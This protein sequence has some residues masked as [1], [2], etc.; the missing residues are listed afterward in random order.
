MILFY[1]ALLAITT[2]ALIFGA[3]DASV[4]E[5]GI[6]A[7]VAEEGNPLIT[8]WAGV[9]PKP[10]QITLYNLVS[11]SVPLFVGLFFGH[12][13]AIGGLMLGWQCANFVDHIKG[14]KEWNW[15]F[16]HP[17][18]KLPDD[19]IWQKFGLWILFQ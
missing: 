4:T 17:G 5:K 9:T 1:I 12:E 3:L 10:W 15:L 6:S 11:V 16:A 7:G 18:Q 8:F 13:A 14:I 2:L 19:T